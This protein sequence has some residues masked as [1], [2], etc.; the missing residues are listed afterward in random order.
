MKAK[1]VACYSIERVKIAT[2]SRR[3]PKALKIA[4]PESEF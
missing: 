3:I 2:G 1:K 4:N